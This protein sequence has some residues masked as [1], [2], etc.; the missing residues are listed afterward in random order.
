MDPELDEK[1]IALARDS[2]AALQKTQ[3]SIQG[4]HSKEFRSQNPF[5]VELKREIEEHKSQK[6]RRISQLRSEQHTGSSKM[7]SV[8]S[9]LSLYKNHTKENPE[10]EKKREERH[11]A[12]VERFNIILPDILLSFVD[13]DVSLE[14]NFQFVIDSF[15]QPD[16]LIEEEESKSLNDNNDKDL[17]AYFQSENQLI[18][19]QIMSEVNRLIATIRKP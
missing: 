7:E 6:S 11:Q 12:L 4:D 15:I 8:M 18:N 1:S 9:R 5:F 13:I 17:I 10:V 14:D 2:H 19:Q 3:S 16:E